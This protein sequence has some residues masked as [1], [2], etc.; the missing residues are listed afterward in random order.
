MATSIALTS[1][2]FSDQSVGEAQWNAMAKWAI[3]SGV[4]LGEL[5]EFELFGDSSGMQ[6]KVRT[7]RVWGYAQFVENDTLR[8]LDIAAADA[9]QARIDRVVVRVN[10]AADATSVAVVTGTPAG[11]PTAPTLSRTGTVWEF[12]L[13]QVLVGAGVSTITAGNITDERANPDVCGYSYS[14]FPSQVCLSTTRPTTFAE[15]GLIFERDTDRLYVNTGTTAAPA[16]TQLATGSSAAPTDATYVTGSA[17]AQLSAELVLGSAVIMLGIL[18]DRPAA[19]LAGRLYFASDDNGGTLYRDSGAVWTQIGASLS[20]SG[21]PTGAS[22][23]TTQSESGLS[24]EQ[25]L[26]TAVVMAD[27]FGNRPAASVNGRLFFATDTVTLYRDNGVT[28]AQVSAA[29]TGAYAPT[30]ASFVTTASESGLSAEK[31]LGTAVIM[32][33]TLAARPAAGTAGRL[34][35]ATDVNSGTLYRDNGSTWDQIAPGISGAT[36]TTLPV[37][38][39]ANQS[40]NTIGTINDNELLFAAGA[41]EKWIGQFSLLVATSG[42]GFRYNFSAPAGSS[43]SMVG[44]GPSGASFTVLAPNPWSSM[45]TTEQTLDLPNG[46]PTNGYLVVVYFTFANGGNAG[47]VALKWAQKTL[48]AGNAANVLAGSYLIAWKV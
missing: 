47:N 37:Y 28:W 5:N 43:G 35:F 1:Y 9:T 36:G 8:T 39:T 7:G 15:G 41:N 30:N 38:K 19:S 17:N 10:W 46:G 14:Q 22:Y 26:G 11:S 48:D 13:G 16:W 3:G 40:N 2:P 33:G 42:C 12:S 45:I 44:M 31:V 25:V 23:V 34:Y 4:R 20:G 27:T 32:S 18:T 21:A 24:N 29:V 6:V